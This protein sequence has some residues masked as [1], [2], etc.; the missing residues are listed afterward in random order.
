MSN[1]VL[2]MGRASYT[3]TIFERFLFDMDHN[4]IVLRLSELADRDLSSPKDHLKGLGHR[5]REMRTFIL[6]EFF[7]YPNG[8]GMFLSSLYLFLKAVQGVRLQQC[9]VG[10]VY[11]FLGNLDI[12]FQEYEQMIVEAKR[13][14]QDKVKKSRGGFCTNCTECQKLARQEVAPM[15]LKVSMGPRGTGDASMKLEV[16]I[17]DVE[18]G[19]DNGSIPELEE[20]ENLDSRA[21]DFMEEGLRSMASLDLAWETFFSDGDS[22]WYGS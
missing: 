19:D 12:F 13:I 2:K 21:M 5:I 3:C 7:M 8:D 10:D 17:T 6:R 11:K 15:Q 20:A 18:D 16:D 22:S 4:V 1:L 9:P 14:A